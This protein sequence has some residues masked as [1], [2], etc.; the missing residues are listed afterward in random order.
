[1]FK[2]VE[3]AALNCQANRLLIKPSPFSESFLPISCNLK[4]ATFEKFVRFNQYDP[5]EGFITCNL[6]PATCNKK[7]P[8]LWDYSDIKTNS[9]RSYNFWQSG[10]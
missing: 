2:A 5:P 10:C 4:L 3:S 8:I 7:V 9:F 6:Q 1:M